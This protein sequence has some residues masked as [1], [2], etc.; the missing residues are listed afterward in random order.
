MILE[1]CKKIQYLFP[2]GHA[3]A[4]V[5]MSLRI[6][7]YKVYYKEAYY[8]A[9][10]TIRADGFDYETMARGEERARE[11][12][13]AIDNKPREEQTAKD[14]EIHTLLELVIE[15]YCRGVEFLPIDLYKSHHHK[16]QIIDGKLLPPFDTLNGMGATA[17]ESIVEAREQGE[18]LTI[19]DFLS[20]TKVSRTMADTMKELGIMGD[21]PETDQMSLF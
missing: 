16:F 15:S 14:K 11:A 9:F 18:F 1:S 17:A 21:L 3:A 12:I 2:K 5:T 4:Y 20:R 7:Y 19:E 13:A 10:Y 8:A 6:A